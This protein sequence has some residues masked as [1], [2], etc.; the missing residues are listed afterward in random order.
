M[1][2][3]VVITGASSGIGREAALLLASKGFRVLATARDASRGADLAA[4]GGG[5]IEVLPL[6]LTDPA[7]VR[8]C[9]RQIAA[10]TDRIAALINNA[11]T[12]L[13][14]YMEDISSAELRRLFDINF[15]GVADFTREMMPLVRRSGP[16]TRIIIVTSVGGIMGTHG[17]GAYCGTKFALEGVAECM[18][19]ELAPQGIHVCTVVPGIVNTDIWGRNKSVGSK[20]E[21]PDSPNYRFFKE[22]EKWGEWAL[23][24]SPIR[25]V[26]VAEAIYRALTDRKPRMRYIVGS[27]VKLVLALRRHLPGEFFDRI[28]LNSTARRLQKAA[29]PD[30]MEARK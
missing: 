25:P 30:R 26:H 4:A 11:G 28:L 19:L 5:K 24:A 23:K 2:D 22:S 20:A 8:E 9:A 1:R 18:R 6:E 16:G 15:F 12:Q 17:L 21:N 3:P 14:G 7:S 13:R 27:R 29:A 10:R